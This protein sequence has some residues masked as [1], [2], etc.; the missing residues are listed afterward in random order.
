MRTSDSEMIR[1]R[2]ISQARIH[3]HSSSK[4]QANAISS[5]IHYEFIHK[6][7]KFI[8]AIWVLVFACNA[9]FIVSIGDIKNIVDGIKRLLAASNM[10]TTILL[11]LLVGT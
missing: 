10:L 2:K 4:R 11:L 1:R 8:I 9:I 7:V 3:F 6:T 5:N